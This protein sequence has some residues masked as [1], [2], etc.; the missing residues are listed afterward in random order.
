M[1][2]IVPIVF[3]RDGKV[4]TDS[5][6][7][8]DKFGKR[9][10]NVLAAIDKL[11]EEAPTLIPNFQ[12]TVVQRENPSGG[13]ALKSR[14]FNMTRDGFSILVMGFTGKKALEWKVRYI[15]AFN[16]MEQG[17]QARRKSI[18]EE[19]KRARNTLTSTLARHG[20]NKPDEYR[21][22]T[23]STYVGL[24]GK[25]ASGLRAAKKLPAKANLREH[26]S[27]VGLGMVM[28]SEALTSERIVVTDQRGVEQ[29][30]AAATT[31]ANVVR[32]AVLEER[33]S[34]KLIGD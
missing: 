14:A 24:W 6:D 11:L 31:C 28:L 18:R 27:E 33:E 16:K 10:D 32:N 12:E 29:C 3:A 8:A 30:S 13:K 17:L 22:V 5:H 21:R 1:N 9:H 2:E 20:V 7:I 15:D 34:R 4:F 26:M 25:D 23:N 19:G